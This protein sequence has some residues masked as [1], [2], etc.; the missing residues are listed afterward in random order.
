MENDDLWK[1]YEANKEWI[2]FAD[3]KAI[4]F[5]AIIGVI[6][7]ILYN[8][9]SHILCLG[10][11]NIIKILYIF[12]IILLSLSLL[13]SVC[14]LIPRKS[15]VKNK[16][17]IYYESINKN[18]SNEEEY[19]IEIENIKNLSQHLSSQNYQLANVAS[20]KYSTVKKALILFGIGIF[21]ILVFVLL[22]CLGWSFNV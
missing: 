22:L 7:N 1:I 14:C 15:E 9:A 18:F 10:N 21:L 2:K 20:E 17:I 16:N 11:Y 6:F 3:T 8:L 4:A 5:I 13:F 12:S 19:H